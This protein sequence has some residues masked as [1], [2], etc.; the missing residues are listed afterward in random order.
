MTTY[1][2][3]YLKDNRTKRTYQLCKYAKANLKH[4]TKAERLMN[5]W[6]SNWYIKHTNQ[7]VIGNYIVDL[8]LPDFKTIIELDGIQH[9]TNRIY[10]DKRTEFLKSCGYAVLRF[11]NIEMRDRTAVKRKLEKFLLCPNR[12]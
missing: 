4:W 10:N 1:N 8:L 6:L 3:H 5:G 12:N 7:A 11:K 9:Q 2:K